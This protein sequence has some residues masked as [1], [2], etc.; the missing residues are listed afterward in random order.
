MLTIVDFSLL[1]QTAIATLTQGFLE[2]LDFTLTYSVKRAFIFE[3]ML[4]KTFLYVVRE[5]TSVIKFMKF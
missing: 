4:M 3:I 1:E 5:V 2:N